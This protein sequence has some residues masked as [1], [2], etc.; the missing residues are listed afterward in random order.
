MSYCDH[1]AFGE[2][3]VQMQENEVPDSG[4]KWRRLSLSYVSSSTAC[5]FLLS[6]P[7]RLGFP[8]TQLDLTNLTTQT[9]NWTRGRGKTTQPNQHQKEP[10]HWVSVPGSSDCVWESS[11]RND[12]LFGLTPQLELSYMTGT[13]GRLTGRQGGQLGSSAA[14][15]EPGRDRWAPREVEAMSR[16]PD[17]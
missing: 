14:G 17:S 3:S 15:R 16:Q 13:D 2:L 9:R 10:K 11:Q 5:K 4:S 12:S 1:T 7:K 6:S 8:Q